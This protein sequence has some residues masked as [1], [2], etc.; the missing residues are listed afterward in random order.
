VG[1]TLAGE[2]ILENVVNYPVSKI[3]LS[4]LKGKYIILDFWG[5]FCSSCIVPLSRLDSFQNANKDKVQVITVSDFTKEEDVYKLFKR[6]RQTKNL[7]LPVMLGSPML[8]NYFP[9][10]IVSHLVWIGSDGVVKAITGSDYVTQQSFQT[11]LNGKPFNWPVKNDIIEFDYKKPLFDFAQPALSK[12]NLLYY[13]TL[14]SYIDGIAPP[15]GT[16]IDSANNVAVTAFYNC[17]LL[18]LCGLAMD[19]RLTTKRDKFILHVQD[20]A[21]YVKVSTTYYKEWA[22]TNTYC[23]YLRTPIQLSEQQRIAFIQSDILRWLSLLGVEV[24]KQTLNH[25]GKLQPVY[26]VSEKKGWP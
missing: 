19:Y 17:T 24:K 22:I 4:D 14:T 16:F 5:R 13:S 2:I 25:N 18:Q 8:A 6:F 15:T 12:P 20:S 11:L 10:Q 21:K 26:I 7:K 1:D 23:Y 3:Q 9:H